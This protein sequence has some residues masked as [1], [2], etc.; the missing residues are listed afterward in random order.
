[1]NRDEQLNTKWKNLPAASYVIVVKRGRL[2][3]EREG[4][5][6]G[7]NL[8]Q[9]RKISWGEFSFLQIRHEVRWFMCLCEFEMQF[10]KW[11]NVEMSSSQKDEDDEDVHHYQEV[12]ESFC[13]SCFNLPTFPIIFYPS[14][15]HIASHL[16]HSSNMQ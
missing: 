12:F 5:I 3:M 15:R 2:F 16:F 6:R 14:L 4:M 9:V 13:S 11:M 10:C 8:P 7:G 1:M